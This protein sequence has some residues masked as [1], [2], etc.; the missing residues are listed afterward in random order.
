MSVSLLFLSATAPADRFFFLAAF[1]E[2]KR[3]RT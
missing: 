1:G 3:R 2:F